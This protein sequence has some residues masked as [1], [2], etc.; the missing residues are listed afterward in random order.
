MALVVLRGC[1]SGLLVLEESSTALE[2]SINMFNKALPP[3][4]EN[5]HRFGFFAR[6]SKHAAKGGLHKIESTT[7]FQELRTEIN[8]A[9]KRFNAPD[10]FAEKTIG[11]KIGYVWSCVCSKLDAF[12]ALWSLI[13]DNSIYTSLFCG[14]AKMIVQVRAPSARS[15]LLQHEPPS[16]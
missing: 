10:A 8:S 12:Q 13:P 7:T 9:I 16:Y 11:Q 5:K 4:E 6:S 3:E 14:V 2:Q 15:S 1:S